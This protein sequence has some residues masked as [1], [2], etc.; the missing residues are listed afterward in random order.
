MG[1]L[2][3]TVV[4]TIVLALGITVTGAAAGGEFVRARQ[5]EPLGNNRTGP[6]YVITQTLL[7]HSSMC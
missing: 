4:N 2:D 5:A 1:N 7:V 3:R 6:R